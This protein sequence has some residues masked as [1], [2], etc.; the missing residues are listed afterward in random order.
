MYEVGMRGEWRVVHPSIAVFYNTSELGTSSAG[1]NQ[2][3]V[4]APER[5]YGIEATLDVRPFERITLGT[6]TSWL[7]GKHDPNRDD[8]YTY[9][10]SWRIPPVK[11]TSYVDVQTLSRW[12]NR[13]Q[14]LYSG[15]RDRFPNSNAFGERPVESYATVDW[16]SA[17]EMP[18]G[19]IRLGIQNLLNR[20]Y[21]TRDSQLLRVGGNLSYAAAHGAAFSLSYS[22]TY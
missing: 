19:V 4:R 16:L 8:I 14:V 7:E 6:S 18:R 13:F 2:P 20:Q 5:V 12:Q 15:T 10:N 21:F 22:L 9:L 17:V 1:F 3:V 11:V